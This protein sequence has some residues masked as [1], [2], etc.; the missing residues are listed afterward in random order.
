MDIEELSIG[1]E[2]PPHLTLEGAALFLDLDGTLAPIVERPQDVGPDPRRSGLLERLAERLHGRLAVVS[3]RS[4]DDIDRILEGKVMCVAAI[5][6][7]IRRDAR[8]VVGE[9]PPHPGIAPARSALN[10]FASSDPRLI[11]EDKALSLTIHYRLAPDRARE[12]ISLAERLATVTGLTLQPGDMVMELRTP[13][14]SKGDSI[15]AFMTEAPF[16]GARPVFLGDDLTDEHGFF[17]VRQLGGH[18]V[19]VGP[20]R[21]TTAIYRMENVE[22]ALSWLEAAR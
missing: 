12:A 19:L 13:G 7:L 3:G 10:D 9:A 18:G 2:K 15:R 20:Q 17:A 6:G 1:L 4:L 16:K 22:A 21:R 11:I 14:A 8:G 5:H